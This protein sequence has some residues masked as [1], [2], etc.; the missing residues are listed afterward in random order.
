MSSLTHLAPFSFNPME[1]ENELKL[2]VT[3]TVL[4]TETKGELM[5]KPKR[6]RSNKAKKD[7]VNMADAVEETP[8]ATSPTEAFEL[9]I[10]TEQEEIE[11][12]K[13]E[14]A[15]RPKKPGP[16]LKQLIRPMKRPK[17]GPKQPGRNEIKARR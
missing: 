4:E 11:E 5:P 2:E 12:P 7:P 15:P 8:V 3:E 16:P 14:P 10:H 17:S 13:I 1:S 9:V 6:R